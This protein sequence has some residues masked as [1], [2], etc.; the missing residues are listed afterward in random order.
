ML[1]GAFHRIHAASKG[2]YGLRGVH[3]GLALGYGVRIWRNTV[4]MLMARAGLKGIGGRPKRRQPRPD[5]ASSDLVDRQFQ[6]ERPDELWVTDIT[7]HPTR[8]GEVYC[9]VVFDVCSRRVVG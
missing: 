4:A 1:T 9:A 7:E 6:R 8:E 3:A 2:V 5:L